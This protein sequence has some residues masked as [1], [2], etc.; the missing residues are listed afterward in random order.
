MDF[1]SLFV[2]PMNISYIDDLCVDESASGE[3]I[4]TKLY[5]FVIDFAKKSG[6]YNITL[7]VWANNLNA[8]KFYKAIGMSLQTLSEIP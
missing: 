8:V 1:K 4:D 3:H 5:N 2:Y 6:C 7:T